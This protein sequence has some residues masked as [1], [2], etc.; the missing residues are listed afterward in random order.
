MARTLSNMKTHRFS[1][2]FFD[3]YGTILVYGDM[4][5]AWEEW[6]DSIRDSLKEFGV[7]VEKGRLRTICTG[8]FSKPEPPM[9][10]AKELTPYERRIRALGEQLGVEFTAREMS[11]I[12]ETSI[13][14]WSRHT[15]PDPQAQ[16]LLNDLWGSHRIALI[17][18]F[19]HPPHV[20]TRLAELGLR[21]YF[22]A[23]VVSGE[24]GTKKPG[25]GIFTLA[26]DKIGMAAEDV[27]FIGD[28]IEDDIVGAKAIGMTPILIERKGRGIEPAARDFGSENSDTDSGSSTAC[29]DGV[30]II[31]SLG[32]LRNILI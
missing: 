9:D 17:T 23:V 1:G 25:P 18:N 22:D 20:H 21:Q 19:D 6:F 11:D 26:L 28:S 27:A 14:S 15:F 3:L 29:M 24:V 13:H 16:S 30:Q 4:K 32:A 8:F 31:S 2:L 12:S 10:G 5:M 7:K